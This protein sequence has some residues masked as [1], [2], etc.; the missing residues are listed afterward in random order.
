[1]SRLVTFFRG[2]RDRFIDAELEESA[3]F[4]LFDLKLDVPSKD[5]PLWSL[6]KNLEKANNAGDWVNSLYCHAL[7]LEGALNNHSYDE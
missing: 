7:L 4:S 2:T 5:D 6:L 3:R 1:M